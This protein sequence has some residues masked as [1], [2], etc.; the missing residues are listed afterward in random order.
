MYWSVL[1]RFVFL[2][3]F[4]LVAW[5]T[6]HSAICYETEVRGLAEKLVTGLDLADHKTGSV[7]DFTNLDG[8][9][10]MLGRFLALELA[11]QLVAVSKKTKFVDRANLQYLLREN[12]MTEGGLLDPATSKKLGKVAGIDTFIVGTLV[13]LG[14]KIRLSVRAIAAETQIIVA[15]QSTT[16]QTSEFPTFVRDDSRDGDRKNKP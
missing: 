16:L 14:D 13:V 2:A 12:K 6:P 9:P 5:T 7:L 15:S 8:T 4:T 1:R 11:D 10:S 3:L